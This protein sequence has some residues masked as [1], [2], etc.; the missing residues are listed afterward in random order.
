MKHSFERAP[1][2]TIAAFSYALAFR[3]YEDIRRATPQSIEY[4]H[5][6]S[7]FI[8]FLVIGTL[9]IGLYIG[10]LIADIIS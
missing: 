6:F 8:I 1:F 3:Y 9:S 7:S 2:L 5:A 4:K 10:L